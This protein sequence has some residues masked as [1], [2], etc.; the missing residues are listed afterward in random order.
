[1]EVGPELDFIETAHAERLD[2]VKRAHGDIGSVEAEI[3]SDYWE[4]RDEVRK[5][6]TTY[7]AKKASRLIV[8]APERNEA[9]WDPGSD[10]RSHLTDV[11]INAMRSAIRAEK[12]AR[13]EIFL[14]WVPGIVGILGTLVGLAAVL[15]KR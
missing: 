5:A 13:L 4:N 11:G 1:M 8:P 3:A 9:M 7:L 12:K 14:M 10:G 6:H 2:K 15:M